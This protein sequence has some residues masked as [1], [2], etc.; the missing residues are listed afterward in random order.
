MKKID[1]VFLANRILLI[2]IAIVALFTIIYGGPFIMWAVSDDETPVSKFTSAFQSLL[3]GMTI[4][5]TL[6]MIREFVSRQEDH[7]NKINTKYRRNRYLP[8]HP[9]IE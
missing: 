7:L 1:L 8:P 2:V 4:I 5:V 6:V 9:F 3:A